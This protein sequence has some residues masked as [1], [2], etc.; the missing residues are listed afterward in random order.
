LVPWRLDL[1]DNAQH[2]ERLGCGPV[3]KNHLDSRALAESLRYLLH[4]PEVQRACRTTQARMEPGTIACS[5]A[6]DF[7]EQT[8]RM[9]TESDSRGVA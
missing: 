9:A 3:E 1:F 8:F 2:V 5:H 4:A 7:I 6:A